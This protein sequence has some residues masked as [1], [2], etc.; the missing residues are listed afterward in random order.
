MAL[1]LGVLFNRF[2]FLFRED[3]KCKSREIYAAY[4]HAFTLE[5]KKDLNRN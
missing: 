2:L 4:G 1:I 3:Y 5:E